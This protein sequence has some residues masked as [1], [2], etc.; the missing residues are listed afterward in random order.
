MPQQSKYSDQQFETLMHDIIAV[1][2]K[3]KADRDLSLMAL[4]N[5]VTNIF[6]HQVDDKHRQKMV[7]QFTNVLL[8]SVNTK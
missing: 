6:Q 8:K 1:L 2:E 3:N 4:G 7:E 5:I